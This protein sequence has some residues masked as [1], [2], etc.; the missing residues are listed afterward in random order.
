[1]QKEAKRPKPQK[2][3]K[4]GVKSSEFGA[5][6]DFMA[7]P[8]LLPASNIRAAGPARGA[9]GPARGAGALTPEKHGLVSLIASNPAIDAGGAFA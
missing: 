1:M 3:A 2:R 5:I 4:K 8:S 7:F 6:C 9:A